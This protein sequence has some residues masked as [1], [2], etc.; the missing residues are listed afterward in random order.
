MQRSIVLWV[1]MDFSSDAAN[2]SF[3]LQF[4][5]YM[6]PG[7]AFL[8]LGHCLSSIYSTTTDVASY[9]GR[10]VLFIGDR[11]HAREC[12]PVFLHLTWRLCLIFRCVLC[13]LLSF[14][15]SVLL[16]CCPSGCPPLSSKDCVYVMLSLR[17][18]ARLAAPLRLE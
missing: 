13:G 16:S 2:A 1:E 4:Y 14:L 7:E 5:A 11:T 18:V 15:P 10:L 3:L 6:Q 9:H 17:V 8:V 12:A